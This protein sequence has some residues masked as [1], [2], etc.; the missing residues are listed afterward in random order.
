[1]VTPICPHALTQRPLVLSQAASIE[2]VVHTRGGDVSLTVDGQEGLEL[3]DGDRVAIHCSP[4]PVEMIASAVRNRF[5]ILREKLRW[6][7]R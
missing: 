7:E 6:G 5:E 3:R 2:V 1:M 4:H